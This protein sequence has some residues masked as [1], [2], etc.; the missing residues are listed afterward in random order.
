MSHA[1]IEFCIP[2][3][4]RVFKLVLRPNLFTVVTIAI[5]GLAL[6]ALVLTQVF[7]YQIESTIWLW[8]ALFGFIFFACFINLSY[9]YYQ[10][11]QYLNECFE[12]YRASDR[13]LRHLLLDERMEEAGVREFVFAGLL[14]EMV[15]S[16]YEDFQQFL[17]FDISRSTVQSYLDYCKIKHQESEPELRIWLANNPDFDHPHGPT[18]THENDQ[19][20]GII[21]MLEKI[22]IK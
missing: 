4:E 7:T 16:N 17:A 21:A 1:Q 12:R 20:L 19:R 13:V 8:I 3:N 10:R 5:S 11:I 6:L 14:E 2:D 18:S 9:D 15:K 22:I